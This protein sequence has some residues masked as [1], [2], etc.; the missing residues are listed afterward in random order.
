[1]VR[2]IE[3]LVVR[4]GG[5][6]NAAH[7]GTVGPR[8]KFSFDLEGRPASD[9]IGQDWSIEITNVKSLRKYLK[10]RLLLLQGQGGV[11]TLLT[12]TTDAINYLS[13]VLNGAQE[14]LNGA[15]VGEGGPGLVFIDM[16]DCDGCG[17]AGQGIMQCTRCSNAFY[18]SQ[19]CQTG[20]YP[21][22]RLECGRDEPEGAWVKMVL[23]L[24]ADNVVLERV[25]CLLDAMVPGAP[26]VRL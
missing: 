18:C 22:H 20:H 24:A 15:Q 23:P 6:S 9:G 16:I 11:G 14:V 19:T 26:F 1:M 13:K 4:A 21:L 25:G 2:S 7:V 10:S 8:F 3:E 17:T 12:R 5:D